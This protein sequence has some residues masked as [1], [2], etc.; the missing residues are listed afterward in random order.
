LHAHG[1]SKGVFRLYHADRF[2]A[3]TSISIFMRGSASPAAIIVAEGRTS[4]KYLRRTAQHGSKSAA[5]GKM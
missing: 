5:A 2:L 1:G 4:P 3:V